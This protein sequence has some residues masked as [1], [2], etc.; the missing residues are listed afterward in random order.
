MCISYDAL[1]CQVWL[2]PIA[3]APAGGQPLCADHAR[4]AAL[5]A[6][7]LAAVSRAMQGRG[8]GSGI[9]GGG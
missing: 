1:A 8:Q 6:E 4:V 7:A 5:D 3:M 9:R 2:D